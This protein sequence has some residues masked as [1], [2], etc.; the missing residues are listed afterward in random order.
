MELIQIQESDRRSMNLFIDLPFYIY[1]NFPQW[2]P[3]I[4]SDE[5][6]RFNRKKYPFF[7]HSDAAFFLAMDG[8][9]ARGRIAVLD[10]QLYNNHNQQK[11]AF[12]YLFESIDDEKTS[13]ELFKAAEE[14][15]RSRGLVQMIGPKGFTALDGFGLL[16]KGFEHRPA[17]GIPYNPLYYEKLIEGYG[18]SILNE[19][20]SGYLD[21][22][23]VFPPRIHELAQRI[24]DRRELTIRRFKNKKEFQAL[25]P[26]FTRL[27]KDILQGT[28]DATPITQAEIQALSRQILLFSDL[29][30]I[31]IVCKTIPGQPDQM[32][33]FLLAYPD[34]SR[35]LQKIRGRLYPFGWL[36]VLLDLKKTD[37]ININGAGLSEDFRGS[38]GTAI[39]FSEM[40]K[41]VSDNR[42][43]RHADIV[44]I[45][46][47]NVKMLREMENFGISFYKTHR[48]YRKSMI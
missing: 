25:I 37:W 41:S 31:K 2:V 42:R 15:S 39:L 5:E 27:Y 44:Q 34:I 33:G 4:R 38:G 43:Y 18:F 29:S 26:Q 13:R 24:R 35:S 12:F 32:V 20:I 9:H 6:E 23:M 46:T 30:L 8:N 14:W 48:L 11:A 22:K 47:E 36:Q 10:N 1:K 28:P 16:V 7:K 40:Y 3:P 19:S 45:G 21:A 17:L